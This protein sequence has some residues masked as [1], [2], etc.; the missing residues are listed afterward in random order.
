MFAP[1]FHT[2][3]GIINVTFCALNLLFCS[4]LVYGVAI[5]KLFCF[6]DFKVR[7]FDEL[8]TKIA[9]IFTFNNMGWMKLTTR[10]QYETRG[11]GA[12]LQNTWYL[13]ICNHQSWSD[14]LILE[15]VFAFKVAM[16]KFFVKKELFW[17]P[18]V[19]TSCFALNFPFMKRYS[20][21]FI[22]KNPHLKGKDVETTKKACARFSKTPATL[23]NFVEGTRFTPAKHHEQQSP[24]QNLLRPKAGGI[25]FALEAMG[26]TLANIIDVTIIYPPS[27]HVMWDFFCGNLKKIIIDVKLRPI[28]EDLRGDY[29]K[30]EAYKLHFQTWLN[31]IWTEK[32]K[33]MT[34]LKGH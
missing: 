3:I 32:D 1:V 15:N 4:I 22:E 10:T 12:L 19:G 6:G 31:Q 25:A 8:G 16:L 29:D 11:I 24:Y 23:I 13:L 30:D 7:F 9:K 27:K 20:R 14:I 2:F 18:L 17:V 26:A 5:L 21:E 33:L 34:A 28:T